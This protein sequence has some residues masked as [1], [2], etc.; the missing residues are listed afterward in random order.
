MPR[1]SID[2]VAS[3]RLNEAAHA[4]A[5]L[6][7]L[8]IDLLDENDDSLIARL[9]GQW[10]RKAKEY[11][12]DAP[13]SRV[14]RLHKG[15]LEYADWFCNVWLDRHINGWTE[16]DDPI[17]LSLVAGGRRGGKTFLLTALSCA[18]ACAVPGAI[19][20][21]V[22]PSDVEGYGEE[23]RA[24]IERIMPRD[25]YTSL[26]S[27]HWRYDLVN[28]SCIRFL[29]GFSS[30]KLKKG[31]ASLV[32]INEAQQ[33]PKTSYN[34]AAASVADEGGMVIAA[35]NP[36]DT[37]DKGTWVSDVAAETSNGTR[38]NAKSFFIDP[39]D[40]PHI[41]YRALLALRD[42]MD[43]HEFDVQIR[44][45]FLNARNTVLHA[46]NRTENERPRPDMGECTAQFTRWHE[47]VAYDHIV[48]IDVQ[49]FPWMVASVGHA[50][51][52]P[53]APDDMTQAFIWFDD[54]VFIENGDEVDTAEELIAKGYKPYNTL[55]ICD[56]SGD[57][58]QAERNVEMQRPEYKGKGS[59]DMLRGCGFTNIVGP[60]ANMSKNPDVV[61]RVR[62]AN[63]RIGTKSRKR[64]VFAD[65]KRAPRSVRTIGDWKNVNGIP[66]RRAKSAHCGDTM[67]YLIWR[68]FPRR[69]SASGKVEFKVL[70]KFEGAKRT[71]GFQ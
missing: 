8:Q 43:E 34:N 32:F 14:I 56:A 41:D 18:Y 22:T 67:T 33:V 68:F 71:R 12:G 62:A 27:P 66:S 52:N 37:G 3:Q 36:P 7:N 5:R 69:K 47:G 11:T 31:T 25:W 50:Y 60:D 35:A 23:L 1:Q 57:Y 58:Q 46:W 51:R 10:D 24:Y 21:I 63:G 55:V 39:L 64:Y 49:K 38:V 28:G 26:G 45:M 2:R 65:P 59:W 48:S 13:R 61:E 42:S 9:G 19:V 70:K 29:S 40:N 4:S 15:Q 44:G 53:E 17:Y 16:D 20:W 6:C 30:G 54:E